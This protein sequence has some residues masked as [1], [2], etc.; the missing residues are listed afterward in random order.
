MES[1]RVM[2]KAVGMA[3]NMYPL[4]CREQVVPRIPQR[5]QHLAHAFFNEEHVPWELIG[6]CV[7]PA[8]ARGADGERELGPTGPPSCGASRFL[9]AMA[10]AFF[11]QH[12]E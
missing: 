9:Q 8:L 2:T 10:K 3:P 1:N 6:H 5:L 11:A 7:E 12:P 4:R